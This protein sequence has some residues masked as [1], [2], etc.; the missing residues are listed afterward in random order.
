MNKKLLIG[1]LVLGVPILVA[2]AWLFAIQANVIG[3]AVSLPGYAILSIDIP[4]LSVNTTEAPD[5][6]SASFNITINRD[7]VL[8][9]SIIEI[10]QDG[11]G[12]D[13][14][15]GEDDCT[16]VYELANGSVLFD[17]YGKLIDGETI[18]IA[19]SIEGRPLR[20][21]MSCI[22]YSCPQTRTADIILTE[23]KQN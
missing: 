6:D 16:M 1:L 13:C 11:S 22:A 23:V 17:G 15:G 20:V 8:N 21:T 9:V 18:N 12:G 5:S 2:A 10:Y 19:A 7:T 3:T 4:S 14:E